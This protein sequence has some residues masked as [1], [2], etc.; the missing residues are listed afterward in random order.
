MFLIQLYLMLGLVYSTATGFRVIRVI[1]KLNAGDTVKCWGK[2]KPEA[3]R[4]ANETLDALADFEKSLASVG[5]WIPAL[6]GAVLVFS[7]FKDIFFYP[8]GI[9]RML[10]N[11]VYVRVNRNGIVQ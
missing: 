7:W 1:Q 10:N 6:I 3:I 2:D 4:R 11:K 5:K 9:I 8:R